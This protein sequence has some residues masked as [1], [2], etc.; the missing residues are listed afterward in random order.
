VEDPQRRSP[1]HLAAELAHVV[2]TQLLLWV[3]EWEG[4]GKG[5]LRIPSRKTP[6]AGE[7]R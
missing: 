2:I 5:V 3:S 4:V 7:R 6:G 1:L